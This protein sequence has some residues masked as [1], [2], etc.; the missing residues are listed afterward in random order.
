MWKDDRGATGDFLENDLD[1]IS[2]KHYLA[3]SASLTADEHR[4]L[5][6]WLGQICGFQDADPELA[7]NIAAIVR[8]IASTAQSYVRTALAQAAATNPRIPADVALKIANDEDAVAT[9]FLA[10]SEVLTEQDLLNIA[11]LAGSNAKRLA[12]SR[13]PSVSE[14][15][16]GVLA[17]HGDWAVRKSLLE[18]SGARIGDAT[19]DLIVARDGDLEDMHHTVVNGR[20]LPVDIVAKFIRVI[21]ASLIEQLVEK[22]GLTPAQALDL[23]SE[24]KGEA[25]IGLASDIPA[26]RLAALVKFL[27]ARGEITPFLLFK[28]VC[29]GNGQ[30]LAAYLAQCAELPIRTVYERLAG[31]HAR[32]LG[33]LWRTT[34]F[35]DD[36]LPLMIQ[37]IEILKRSAL[38]CRK[39]DVAAQRNRLYQRLISG[40]ETI[41]TDLKPAE[42]QELWAANP[43]GG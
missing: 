29:G 12:I 37:A 34:G 1:D 11:G 42:V 36:L 27:S 28:A 24:V 21:E 33:I 7:G 43:G 30:L 18:N 15:L 8:E 35:T 10:L 41:E 19:Y 9:P 6:A 26:D 38:D 5:A 39:M 4:S 32:H 20:R 16:S 40:L 13:R 23:A 31:D 17:E 2:L 14:A 22:H 25:L 3:I